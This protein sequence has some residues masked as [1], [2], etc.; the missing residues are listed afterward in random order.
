MRSHLK[1]HSIGFFRHGSI[2]LHSTLFL[3]CMRLI[4]YFV[5]REIAFAHQHLYSL[6]LASYPADLLKQKYK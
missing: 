3:S 1:L 6:F 2:Y 5:L 4:S